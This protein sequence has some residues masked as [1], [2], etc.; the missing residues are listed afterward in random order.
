[1]AATPVDSIKCVSCGHNL[2]IVWDST[3]NAVQVKPCGCLGNQRKALC[4]LCNCE[5]IMDGNKAF[6][7]TIAYFHC[8]CQEAKLNTLEKAYKEI[9]ETCAMVAQEITEHMRK[10]IQAKHPEII[11]KDGR[12]LLERCTEIV[13]DA[14]YEQR[15]E[16]AAYIVQMD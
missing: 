3:S 7:T 4:A 14:S 9:D 8:R 12:T 10:M 2:T 15:L 5:L 6:P 1:M 11:K 13:A 16:I